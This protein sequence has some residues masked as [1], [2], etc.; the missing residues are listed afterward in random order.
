MVLDTGQQRQTCYRLLLMLLWANLVILTIEV[1]AGWVSQSVTLLAEALHTLIDVFSTALSLTAIASPQRIL[2][3]EIWGHGR[4]EVGSTLMLAALLG[5]F[6]VNILIVALSQFQDVMGGATNPFPVEVTVA[7]IQLIAA[8]VAVAIG[9]AFF[10]SYRGRALGSIALKL[11]TQHVL[12]NGWLSIAMLVGL[13]GIWRG[14]SWLDP[15]MAIALVTL[16]L[17]SFWRVLNTQLPMLL[18]PTAI[19]PEAIAQVVTTVEGVT[20]C[21]RIRSRGMVGRQVWIELYLAV[22]PEC[23]GMSR[24]IG[25]RVDSALRHHYGPVSTQVWVEE[26]YTMPLRQYY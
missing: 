4:G 3:K 9:L 24:T 12:D 1:I 2:G 17:Q 26:D 19:A 20:R 23:L 6:G 21:N 11:T 8:M 16:T 10:V 5:C 15:F 18:K 22:H 13:I 14:Y 25:E 7:L